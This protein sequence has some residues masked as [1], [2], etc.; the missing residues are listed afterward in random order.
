MTSAVAMS[1]FSI[2]L[3]KP[4]AVLERPLCGVGLFRLA[5]VV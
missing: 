4:P 1:D 5:I 3:K 2:L